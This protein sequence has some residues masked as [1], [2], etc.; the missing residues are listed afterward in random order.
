MR[1]LG[2][3]GGMS[4]E[5][6]V[7]YY[8]QINQLIKQRLG[9]LHSARL[10]LYSVDFH[11]MERLMHAGD[12]DGAGELLAAAARS[13]ETAGAQGLV[14]CTN[15]LHKVAGAIEAAVHIPLLHIVD[16]TAAEIVQAGY[17]TVG[18]LGTRFVMEQAFYSDRLAAHG[19]RVLCPEPCEREIIHRVIFEE[20]CLGQVLAAS[21]TQYR[22]IM[23]GLAARGAQAII[24]GCT[25]LSML[26]DAADAPVALFDTTA[27]HARRAAEW[28]LLAP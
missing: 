6:T 4:W 26:V 12:W 9:G 11:D 7:P 14:L 28:S 13:L 27:V 19:L 20:L 5:S 24:L 15:T 10:I 2:L 17:R 23:H 8:R 22:D 21:R 25:E 3:L 1:V 16:V 18:L